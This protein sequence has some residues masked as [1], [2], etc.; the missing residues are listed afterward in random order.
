M[1]LHLSTVDRS[2]K[3]TVRAV[4]THALLPLLAALVL[5]ACSSSKAPIPPMVNTFPGGSLDS[6]NSR[7]N[8]VVLGQASQEPDR[9]DAPLGAGDLLEI[10][11]ADVPELQSLKLRVTPAGS[12]LVSETPEALF[13]PALLTTSE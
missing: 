3:L 8:H 13:G 1:P 12:T 5:G 6:P 9:N 7:I 2:C 10:Q 11:V 4:L